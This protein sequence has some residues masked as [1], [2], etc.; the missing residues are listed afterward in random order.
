MSPQQ[1][2]ATEDFPGKSD[3]ASIEPWR[4]P[5]QL[6]APASRFTAL[7]PPASAELATAAAESEVTEVHVSI[8]RIEVTAVHEATPARRPAKA[9]KPLMSLDDY[10]A[11][12]KRVS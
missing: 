3:A 7:Q 6:V 10:L 5:P 9:A 11:K 12:R 1:R 2:A 8:G 4:A